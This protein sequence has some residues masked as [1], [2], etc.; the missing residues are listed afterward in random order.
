MY[1]VR[2]VECTSGLLIWLIDL[3]KSII[4][5]RQAR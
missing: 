2:H 3:A 5:S 4:G 1:R